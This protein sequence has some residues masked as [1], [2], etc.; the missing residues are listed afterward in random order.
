MAEIKGEGEKEAERLL[1]ERS[2]ALLARDY[3]NWPLKRV[4]FEVIWNEFSRSGYK[5]REGQYE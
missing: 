2:K 3:G 4:P 5:L 1:A